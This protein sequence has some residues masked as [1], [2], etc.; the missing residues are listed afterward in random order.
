[1][2]SHHLH[3]AEGQAGPTTVGD[4]GFRQLAAAV[5]QLRQHLQALELRVRQLETACQNR[6]ASNAAVPKPADDAALPLLEPLT[7]REREILIAFARQP[8]DAVVAEQLG[9]KRQTIRNR[10]AIIRRKLH[11]SSR[12]ELLQLVY[13]Q[14]PMLTEGR[15]PKA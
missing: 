2:T 13:R 7:A 10:L 12:S 4:R 3:R 8:N 14:M 6:T 9:S 15:S 5:D 11:V 1:M